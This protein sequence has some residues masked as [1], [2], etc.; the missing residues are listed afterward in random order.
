[1]V[2]NYLR[3]S[4]V[5]NAVGCH[6]NTVRLYVDWGY[7]PQVKRS[8]SNYRL[9]TNDHLE[10]IKLAR[11]A[12]LLSL[13]FGEII[14]YAILLGFSGLVFWSPG[15][16][17]TWIF[18]ALFQLARFPVGLYPGWLRMVLTWVIPVGIMT[19]F[20][21][22][23]LAGSLTTRFLLIEILASIIFLIGTS[24]LFRAGIKRYASASS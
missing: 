19:T 8:K 17:F 4:E 3:T 1:M 23:A 7:I 2:R 14:M 10:H 11:I 15:F 5:A 16:L 6:P 18:D 22:Q 13:S 12:F 20:P 21:A 24:I 9:F